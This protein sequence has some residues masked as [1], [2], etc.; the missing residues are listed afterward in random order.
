MPVGKI[1]YTCIY[2]QLSYTNFGF[3]KIKICVDHN[4][5]IQY[6]VYA[7]EE[8]G[9]GQILPPPPPPPPPL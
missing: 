5:T 1:F 7:S 9:K 4:I 6:D 3:K 2:N 8:G